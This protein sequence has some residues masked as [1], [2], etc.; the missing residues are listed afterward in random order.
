MTQT[1]QVV[2]LEELEIIIW[3]QLIEG[4]PKKTIAEELVNRELLTLVMTDV[5][6]T[7]VPVD[8]SLVDERIQLFDRHQKSEIRKSGIRVI[9]YAVCMSVASAGSGFGWYW[10]SGRYE[11]PEVL[12]YVAVGLVVS[13]GF[14]AL[15]NFV[16]GPMIIIFGIGGT[17]SLTL[18]LKNL[19]VRVAD[20][21]NS[22]E[23]LTR[24]VQDEQA[25]SRSD[26]RRISNL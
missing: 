11:L 26:T 24:S 19:V 2:P 4:V 15:I 22:S 9:L 18:R 16:W 12:G 10:F 21:L 6:V 20:K 8:R 3:N 14:G 13:C 1:R 5:G 25:A 23:P 17:R 7:H